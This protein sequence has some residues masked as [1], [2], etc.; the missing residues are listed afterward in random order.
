VYR[1]VMDPHIVV[2]CVLITV[3]IKN[4]RTCWIAHM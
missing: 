3:L 4:S 2:A 1:D